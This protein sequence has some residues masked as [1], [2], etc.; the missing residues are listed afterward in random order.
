[1]QEFQALQNKGCHF[2]WPSFST[3][4]E[5]PYKQEAMQ[6]TSEILAPFESVDVINTNELIQFNKDQLA[7]F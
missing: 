6:S 3:T 7:S 5:L 1:M 4:A 2:V